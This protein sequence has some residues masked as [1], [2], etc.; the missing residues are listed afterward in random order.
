MQVAVDIAVGMKDV[1]QRSSLKHLFPPH[2]STGPPLT[3]PYGQTSPLALRPPR[4]LG[5]ALL[6]VWVPSSSSCRG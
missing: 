4:T 6:W 5:G 2:R 3:P 1:L